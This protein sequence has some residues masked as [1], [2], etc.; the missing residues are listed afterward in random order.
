MEKKSLNTTT[1]L[2]EYRKSIYNLHAQVKCVYINTSVLYFML[3]KAH[4]GYLVHCWMKKWKLVNQARISIQVAL[5]STGFLLFQSTI[6]EKKEY[7]EALERNLVFIGFG[8][9]HGR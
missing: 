3:K 2:N 4:S 6:R 9:R 5:A 1:R 8:L 7:K